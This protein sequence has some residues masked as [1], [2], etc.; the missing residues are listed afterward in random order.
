[1]KA[2]NTVWQAQNWTESK[3]RARLQ[4][5]RSWTIFLFMTMFNFHVLSRNSEIERFNLMKFRCVNRQ[6][7]GDV[8]SQVKV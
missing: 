2:V 3:N 7:F 6:V 5:I 1:M 8:Y 4:N